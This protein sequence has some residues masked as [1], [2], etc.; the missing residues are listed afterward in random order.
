[1]KRL[2]CAS[3]FIAGAVAALPVS[4]QEVRW[5]L[6]AINATPVD[7]G[8]QAF[9]LVFTDKDSGSFSCGWSSGDFA[10]AGNRIVFREVLRIASIRHPAQAA[11]HARA[12]LAHRCDRAFQLTTVAA[13]NDTIVLTG[14]TLGDDTADTFTFSPVST[15]SGNAQ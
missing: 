15:T 9:E 1:M 13:R 7:S 4:A 2:F 12:H 11:A 3:L 14:Q 8:D 5:G 10:I 6:A